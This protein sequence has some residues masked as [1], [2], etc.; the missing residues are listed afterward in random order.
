VSVPEH[1]P[2]GSYDLAI[3]AFT[4]GTRFPISFHRIEQ[5]GIHLT[6]G[7]TLAAADVLY[8]SSATP[9]TQRPGGGLELAPD[10]RLWRPVRLSR[11]GGTLVLGTSDA[12]SLRVTFNGDELTASHQTGTRRRYTFPREI[13]EGLLEIT[14]KSSTSSNILNVTLLTETRR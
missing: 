1:I 3:Q 11:P 5:R 4:N 14:T 6:P 10:T 8:R 13:S 2:P 7:R 12:A 9:R